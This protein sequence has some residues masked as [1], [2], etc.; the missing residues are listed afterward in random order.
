MQVEK[1]PNETQALGATSPIATAETTESRGLEA[2]T[3]DA[4]DLL[5]ASAFVVET[6]GHQPGTD[7]AML[8]LANQR[9]EL[10]IGLGQSL[11]NKLYS[12]FPFPALV[13]T[14]TADWTRINRAG[15]TWSLSPPTSAISLNGGSIA[16]AD[17][18]V[19]P[20][21][22]IYWAPSL[23]AAKAAAASYAPG[24]PTAR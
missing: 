15:V 24:R 8:G 23:A 6:S 7:M 14:N 17:V 13:S 20:L 18:D 22:K 11:D 5:K 12:S 3:S 16:T 2:L 4:P 21:T 9:D 1:V 19:A 10:S